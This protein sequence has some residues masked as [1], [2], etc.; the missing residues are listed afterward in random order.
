ME[1][2]GSKFIDKKGDV[3]E[4]NNIKKH[5]MKGLP[6]GSERFISKLEKKLSMAMRVTPRGRPRKKQ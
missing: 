3:D 1:K 2:I 5:T 4:M 6:I